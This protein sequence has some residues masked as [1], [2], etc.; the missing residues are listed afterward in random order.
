[1][2]RKIRLFV[3]SARG[4][5]VY[6]V[7]EAGFCTGWFVCKVVEI[8]LCEKWWRSVCVQSGGDRFVCRVVEIGLCAKWWRSVCVQSGGDRFV[9]RVFCVQNGGNRFVCE[10]FCV[11]SDLCTE[12]SGFSRWHLLKLVVRGFLQI[13][14]FPPSFIS[15]WFN[16]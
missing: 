12:L 13:L 2:C 8:G 5:F 11:Q 9:C 6:R 14:R 3:C 15:C 1:M 4:D 16:L 7:M 10:V